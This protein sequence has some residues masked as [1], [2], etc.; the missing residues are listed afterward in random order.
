MQAAWRGHKEALEWLML[1]AE[2]PGLLWQLQPL[3]KEEAPT[4]ATE[5]RKGIGAHALQDNHTGEEEEG[6][7][8]FE[9]DACE[10]AEGERLR[11]RAGVGDDRVR[12]TASGSASRQRFE[13]NT[14]IV[15]LNFCRSLVRYHLPPAA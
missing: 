1:D 12:A 11:E 15:A 2:G 14:I 6:A 4:A 9:E 10:A 13:H 5:D 7:R 8:P 3:I